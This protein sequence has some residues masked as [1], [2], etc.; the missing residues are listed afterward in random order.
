MELKKCARI[1]KALSSEQRLQ[2]FLM[3]F[4]NC[5]SDKTCQEKGMHMAFS[6]ACNCMKL[7]KSTVSHHLKEL[8]D[9]GLII[10]RRSGQTMSCQVNPKVLEEVRVL[11]D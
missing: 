1:F 3:I 6:K 2:I 11:F 4:K 9:A 5:R 7:S 10:I 8:Q